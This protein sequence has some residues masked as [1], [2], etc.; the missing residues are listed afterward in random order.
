[1]FPTYQSWSI[2]ICL[3]TNSRAKHQMFPTCRNCPP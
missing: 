3:T 2:W 1:M